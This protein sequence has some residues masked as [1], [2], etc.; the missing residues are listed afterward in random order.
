MKDGKEKLVP[1][2]DNAFGPDVVS[3]DYMMGRE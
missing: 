2:A 1:C 3:R